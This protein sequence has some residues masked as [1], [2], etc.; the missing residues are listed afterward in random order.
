MSRMSLST[1]QNTFRIHTSRPD[2]IRRRFVGSAL[3]GGVMRVSQKT[4]CEPRRLCGLQ[5]RSP[6]CSLQDQTKINPLIRDD[7][8]QRICWNWMGFFFSRWLVL[9]H[10]H[11]TVNRKIKARTKRS[12]LNIS[13][14]QLTS[15]RTLV[16]LYLINRSA[17]RHEP[18][19]AEMLTHQTS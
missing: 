17:I 16:K 6:I 1:D 3:A 12:F 2:V 9:I 18:S 15:R 10:R 19:P 13:S 5:S 7:T 8:I 4:S 11:G 14:G